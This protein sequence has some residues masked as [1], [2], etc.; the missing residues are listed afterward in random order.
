MKTTKET[1]GWIKSMLFAFVIGVFLGFAPD[2]QSQIAVRDTYHDGECQI[3]CGTESTQ[4][5]TYMDCGNGTELCM[6]E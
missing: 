5:C 2:I 3:V 1:N 4:A 6:R